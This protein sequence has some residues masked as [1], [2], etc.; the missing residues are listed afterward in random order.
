MPISIKTNQ[1]TGKRNMAQGG[2]PP[3]AVPANAGALADALR[4]LA[5]PEVGYGAVLGGASATLLMSA[6][7]VVQ[8]LPRDAS[9]SLLALTLA[10]VIMAVGIAA[11]TFVWRR[12]TR[13]RMLAL[14]TTVSALQQ[15]SA[16]AE[17]S[18]RAKT[19]FLATMSHEIRTPMNGVIGMIGLLLETQ[20]MPEQ[21]GY[22]NAAESSG[23]ALLSII[24]EILDTSKIES[25][26]L[27]LEDEPFEV[28]AVAEAVT[29]LLAPR[30]HDK[31][32]EISGH[33]SARV[34]ERIIG[35]QNRLRQILFNLCGNAIKFTDKGGVSL[36]V[37][38]DDSNRLRFK[39]TDTGVGMSE[40]EC[41]R[42]FEEYA[43]ANAATARRFGGTGLGLSI[44]KKLIDRMG[45]T[46]AVTSVPGRGS[47]FSF[48]V[49]LVAASDTIAPEPVLADR[50]YQLA[51]ADGPIADHL[52]A[53]LGEFGARVRRLTGA[54]GLRRALSKADT[55]PTF[56]IICD[57]SH[58][59]LLRNWARKS[60][61]GHPDRKQ[62][63][64]IMRS[65][66]R[67]Q[68]HDLLGPPF[69]G[70]LL[71][72]FRR[73]TL[74]RQLTAG[75]GAQID[76]A[77]SRLRKV[78][79]RAG[80]PFNILLAED[81]PVNMLLARTMLEKAGHRVRHAVTGRQVL[82]LLEKGVAP[83]LVIMDVEMPDLDGLETTRRIRAIERAR[84]TANSLPILALTANARR[85]DHDEC[86]A[87]G[88]N[89]HLSKP[90][91]RHDL[92]EAIARLA[93][94]RRAA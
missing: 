10:G 28:A 83:D 36:T 33:V 31:G 52:A 16:Q 40:D 7:V 38:L 65:E 19:R 56:A 4:D 44:A 22:A 1:T 11:G 91:D 93:P 27:E 61:G 50:T 78:A 5:R 9:T 81:N 34:P 23:R 41:K 90:F 30:A 75:D 64:V 48:M 21:K 63:W 62:V 51:L 2:I 80:R 17:A 67:R 15:A 12:A 18:N 55:E 70:Y 89:G 29:E 85:E 77:V 88:M 84:Q 46:I 6:V 45:G 43:Q 3:T 13:R 87:A 14:A 20:L 35:D 26:R 76:A 8:S 74:L 79:K 94:R 86:L 68:A 73:K 57:S 54:A 92:D 25:G 71:K 82:A 72:P 37:D 69:A 39:V 32:I 60:G 58:A 66:E 49:P 42:I 53:T 59:G 24:D 47:C